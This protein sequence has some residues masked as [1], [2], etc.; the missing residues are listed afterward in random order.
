MVKKTKKFAPRFFGP[1]NRLLVHVYI[2]P[3]T[4]FERNM[5]IIFRVIVLT[6]KSM[7]R[8]GGG[9]T[10]RRIQNHSTPRLTSGA[11]IIMRGLQP[12]FVKHVLRASHY[13]PWPT[14][15]HIHIINS[16]TTLLPFRRIGLDIHITITVVMPGTQLSQLGGL[17][18]CGAVLCLAQGHNFDCWQSRTRDPFLCSLARLP[19]ALRHAPQIKKSLSN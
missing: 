10:A 11:T 17:E 14:C 8:G 4:K 5:F 7:R 9:G 2:C 6:S 15:S 13:Y 16:Q 3:H 18:Q 12:K 1:I 19:L